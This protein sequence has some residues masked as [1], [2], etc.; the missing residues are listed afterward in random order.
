[1]GTWRACG[2]AWR[3][4]CFFWNSDTSRRMAVKRGL[5]SLG[6]AGDAERVPGPP[7]AALPPVRVDT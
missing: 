2:S 7:A 4:S 3:C 6:A 1:M 5:C